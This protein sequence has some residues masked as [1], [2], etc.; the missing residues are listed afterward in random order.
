MTADRAYVTVL[1]YPP[2]M[3]AREQVVA[4]SEALRVDE[5]TANIASRSPVPAIVKT[6]SEKDGD[7]AVRVLGELGIS[8]FAATRRHIERFSNPVEA[9]R[10]MP[11]LGAPSPMYAV[12]PLRPRLHEGGSLVMKDVVVMIVGNIRVTQS[13]S[14]PADPATGVGYLQLGIVSPEAAAVGYVMN[15]ASDEVTVPGS[16]ISKR[17]SDRYLLDVYTRE[18]RCVRIDTDKFSYDLLGDRKDYTERGNLS[19]VCERLRSEAPQSIFDVGFP[20]F[21]PPP[22]VLTQKSRLA[23]H[24]VRT[25]NDNKP[26]FDFYS[27]WRVLLYSKA[28]RSS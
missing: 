20:N 28:A 26:A 7:E 14:T 17:T 8:A 22:D 9:R 12:E 11:A 23:G 4:L 3:S 19:L 10:L 25:V 16:N 6:C 5:Y 13:E 27:P 24:A 21:R 15:R 1:G 18:G 2:D